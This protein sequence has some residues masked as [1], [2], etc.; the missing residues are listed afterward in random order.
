MSENR[1]EGQIGQAVAG[2]VKNRG[3][4][5]ENSNV[6]NLHMA[7]YA[8]TTFSGEKLTFQQ[9]NEIKRLV[10]DL[11]AVTGLTNLEVWNKILSKTG[12]PNAKSIAKELYTDIEIYLSGL[13]TKAKQDAADAKK[14]TSQSN[15]ASEQPQRKIVI[16][17]KT[18][19]NCSQCEETNALFLEERKMRAFL[20]TF[21]GV[22]AIGAIY[23]GIKTYM[24]SSAL[25]DLQA[26]VM[27]CEFDGENYSIG[28]YRR[29]DN[30][31]ELECV[32]AGAGLAPQWKPAAA[33]AKQDKKVVPLKNKPARRSPSTTS[34]DLTSPRIEN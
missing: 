28:S 8:E 33:N 10:K 2:D 30:A 7:G 31:I 5:I 27:V 15:A 23:F 13:I 19:T 4:Q 25:H 17:K 24:L 14:S 32:V 12:S 1:F 6:V 22:M 18:V 16:E 26:R 29:E 9:R 11:M 34:E 21:G 3:N 20:M